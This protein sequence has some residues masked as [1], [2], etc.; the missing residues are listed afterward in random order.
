MSALKKGVFLQNMFMY[1]LISLLTEK[2][3]KLKLK[4]GCRLPTLPTLGQRNTVWGNVSVRWRARCHALAPLRCPKRWLENI[5]PR[6][7]HHRSE[8]LRR[9]ADYCCYW[10]ILLL[11]WILYGCILWLK[12]TQLNGSHFAWLKI[13]RTWLDTLHS[14]TKP[15]QTSH[16]RSCWFFVLANFTSDLVC[17]WS[18]HTLMILRAGYCSNARTLERS[19]T[20]LPYIYGKRTNTTF[21]IVGSC[22]YLCWFSNINKFVSTS[23]CLLCRGNTQIISKAKINC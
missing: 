7:Q 2:C 17:M 3:W 18:L 22:L 21:F 6:W 19:K 14:A 9:R 12:C 11:R 15:G 16:N 20:H 8:S 13:I 10:T 5:K 4:P 23:Y 1:V